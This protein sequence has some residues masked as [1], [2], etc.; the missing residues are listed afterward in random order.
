M[1]TIP[2]HGVTIIYAAAHCAFVSSPGRGS[3]TFPTVSEKPSINVAA[4]P[5][6]RKRYQILYLTLFYC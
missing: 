4:I 6:N 1:M 3:A 2:P 5:L